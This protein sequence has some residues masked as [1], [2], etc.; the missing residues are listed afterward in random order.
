MAR[1]TKYDEQKADKLARF[2]LEGLTIKDACYGVGISDDTFRRWRMRYPD[3]NKKVVEASNRQWESS[4]A[5]AKY[6]NGYRGYKRP[7]I[8]LSVNYDTKTQTPPPDDEKT[9]LEP[10]KRPR[11][12]FYLGLPVRYE[13]PSELVPTPKYYNATTGR[14]EWIDSKCY[15]RPVF[16]SCS[17][18]V[19]LR[20]LQEKA[21]QSEV[22]SWVT[23]I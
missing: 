15:G 23:I 8:A 16:S 10:L 14:V 11:K 7:K 6:H 2:I 17:A 20:K 18:E 13:R 22:S 19:Y 3:F 4:D 1:P 21:W 5:I 12:Q 9:L